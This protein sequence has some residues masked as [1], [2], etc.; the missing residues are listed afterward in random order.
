[1]K[2]LFFSVGVLDDRSINC[3][4]QMSN[5]TGI[6]FCNISKG[7]YRLTVNYKTPN[8]VPGVYTPTFAIRNAITGE[9]YEKR[10]DFLD[11]FTVEGQIIPRGIVHV[12]SEWKIEKT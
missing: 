10:I 5:D 4:W 1:V 3:I 12:E 7:Q 11:T 6:R 8:L 2:E 9:I